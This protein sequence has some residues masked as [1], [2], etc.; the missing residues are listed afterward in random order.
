MRDLLINV[1]NFDDILNSIAPSV[2]PG[3]VVESNTTA[4]P[5]RFPYRS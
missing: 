4:I 1:S 2:E 3:D 5:G